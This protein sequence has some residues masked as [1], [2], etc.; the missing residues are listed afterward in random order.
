MTDEHIA[1][2]KMLVGA[3]KEIFWLTPD[4][5]IKQVVRVGPVKLPPDEEPEPTEVGYL[6]NGTY[7][8]LSCCDPSEFI[9]VTPVFQ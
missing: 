7:I 6:P 9:N 5:E 1:A 2:L 4:N 8:A 3:G